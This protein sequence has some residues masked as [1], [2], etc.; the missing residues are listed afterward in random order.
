MG[1]LSILVWNCDGLNIPHKR[2]SVLTLLRQKKIN[3]ALL[4]ETHLLSKDS[5]R[6]ANRYYHTIASSTASTKSKG[7]AI[8][9]RCNL[10]IKVLD[11]WADDA[12][13]IVIAKVEL[14][15]KKVALISIYA[16]NTFDNCFCDTLTQKM[17][18][19]TDF[20][21]IVGADMNAVLDAKLDR[22]SSTASR[23]QELATDALHSWA[24]SLGLVDM[25][26]SQSLIKR[27]Y[28]LL[29]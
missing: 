15:G 1:E 28:F 22:S 10:K 4:Q 7:V 5:A 8:V 25:A 21:F 18:D 12:G 6:I 24:R 23:E 29:I 14:Y 11:L 9:C 26:V 3:L 16:P 17:L 27:L 13:R 2:S 20:S 19:L